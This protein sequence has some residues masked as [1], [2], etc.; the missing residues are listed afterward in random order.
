MSSFNPFPQESKN[1]IEEKAERLYK[2]EK[3]MPRKLSSRHNRTGVLIENVAACPGPTEVQPRWGSQCLEGG[4][5][6]SSH[7]YQEAITNSQLTAKEKLV[8][9]SGV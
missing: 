8:L 3:L 6:T 5:D 4:V 7:L 9:Y 1:F 2:P